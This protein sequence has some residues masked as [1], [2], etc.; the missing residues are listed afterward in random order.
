MPFPRL[1]VLG[2][3]GLSLVFL[4]IHEKYR[5]YDNRNFELPDK[6]ESQMLWIFTLSLLMLQIAHAASDTGLHVPGLQGGFFIVMIVLQVH[7]LLTIAWHFVR[8][9]VTQHLQKHYPDHHLHAR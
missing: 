8:P 6:C 2:L 5:P 9:Y 7:F 3:L 4:G 1:Q